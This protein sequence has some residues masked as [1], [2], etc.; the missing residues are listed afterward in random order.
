MTEEKR[1]ADNYASEACS[2]KKLHVR[3]NWTCHA[4]TDQLSV[5]VP[6]VP[7]NFIPIKP[8]LYAGTLILILI[9]FLKKC[10]R[11]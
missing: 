5:D 4:A 1:S 11:S 8:L 7:C 9:L 10:N 2:V 3:A 6:L